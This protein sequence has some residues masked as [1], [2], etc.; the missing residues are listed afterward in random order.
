MRLLKFAHSED[1][2]NHLSD[3]YRRLVFDE[4]LCFNFLTLSENRKKNKKKK[5]NQKI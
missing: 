3:S 4:I 5:I 2:K 1:S